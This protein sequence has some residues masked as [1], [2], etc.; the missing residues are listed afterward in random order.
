MPEEQEPQI[1]DVEAT[2]TLDDYAA[3]PLQPD[4]QGTALVGRMTGPEVLIRT[5]DGSLT[6]L[7]L[8]KK[9]FAATD[10]TAE[11]GDEQGRT[12]AKGK[13]A[14]AARLLTRM[15]RGFDDKDLD[16]PLLDEEVKVK[17]LTARR[18]T[19]RL[20]A[21]QF[22]MQLDLWT[23]PLEHADVSLAWIVP[24]EDAKDWLKVTE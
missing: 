7:G 17:K 15:Y 5:S 9:L 18:R 2:K 22:Q 8:D 16:K 21:G 14:D 11:E 19:W 12:T 23:F 1:I 6:Q 20:N 13:R 24:D 10:P 3:V 4:E